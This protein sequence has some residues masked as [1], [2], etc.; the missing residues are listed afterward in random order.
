MRKAVIPIFLFG[1][2]FLGG[3]ALAGTIQVSGDQTP[4]VPGDPCIAGDPS[5]LGTFTMDGS[6]IGCWY[7]DDLTFRE[8]PSGNAQATGHEHF[9][10]CLDLGGDGSCVGD[11]TGSLSF[12]FQFSG[13]YD[14]V[15]FAEI[16]GRCHHPVVS[17]TGGFEDATGVINFKDDV[18]TGIAAYTGN[19]M[20]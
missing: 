11:P 1:L 15:T 9:V 3:A 12:S 6:L 8:Q 4:V 2:T 20:L 10:G 17:G 13:K 14:T 18:A 7:T 16:M 5:S 19:I